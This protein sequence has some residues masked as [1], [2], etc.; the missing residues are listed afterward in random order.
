MLFYCYY[1]WV[2]C[3]KCL[4]FCLCDVL[5]CLDCD[6]LLS[7]VLVLVVYACCIILLFSWLVSDCMFWF[8][9]VCYCLCLLHFGLVCLVVGWYELF[10]GCYCL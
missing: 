7:V 6:S 1:V 5:G 4:Y 10:S 3:G 9:I 2:V 8:L